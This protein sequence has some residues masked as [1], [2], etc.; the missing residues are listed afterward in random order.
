ASTDN[1][2]VVG[3][4]VERNGSPVGVVS[5]AQF[6]DTGLTPGTTYRYAV[7][8]LDKAGNASPFS[9]PITVV[10]NP[11]SLPSMILYPV[12]DAYVRDGSSATKNFGGVDPLLVK[13]NRPGYNREAFVKFSLSGVTG[14][15]SAILHLTAAASSTHTMNSGV[16]AVA[17]DGWTESGITWDNQPAIGALLATFKLKSTSYHTYNLDVTTYVQSALA[18][19]RS[20][21][22]FGLQNLGP[23]STVAR[24]HSRE[25]AKKPRLEIK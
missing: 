7:Q 17:D 23:S 13:M 25:S 9:D 1:V 10:T 16:C 22:S 15:S 6:D 4:D 20:F 18:A 11:G 3:Y 24:I 2:G 14:V 12:A 21:V 5:G 19:G 8:A